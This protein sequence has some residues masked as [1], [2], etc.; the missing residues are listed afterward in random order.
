MR[1]SGSVMCVSGLSGKSICVSIR[2]GSRTASVER[3]DL[4]LVVRERVFK[5]V[6]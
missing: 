4:Y 5:I 6:S 2:F 3:G 1:A